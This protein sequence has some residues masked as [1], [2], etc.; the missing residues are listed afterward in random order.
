MAEQLPESTNP[1]PP[2]LEEAIADLHLKIDAELEAAKAAY[3]DAL[4]IAEID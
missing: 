4:P 3:W 2:E 1:F